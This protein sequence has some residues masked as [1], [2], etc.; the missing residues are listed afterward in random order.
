[1]KTIHEY[2]IEIAD[3]FAINL[4]SGFR[5][6]SLRT[7]AGRTCLWALVDASSPLRLVNFRV[8]GTDQPVPDDPDLFYVGTVQDGPAV[9]HLFRE[10]ARSEQPEE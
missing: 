2:P 3:A 6:L 7:Q 5:I 8:F 1:V 9:W 10:L 4:P